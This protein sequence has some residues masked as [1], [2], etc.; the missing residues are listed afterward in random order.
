Y[1]PGNAYLDALA[2]HRRAKGLPATAIA[3][4]HW[5][6]ATPGAEGR[7][8]R[9]GAQDLDPEAALDV[10]RGILDHDDTSV[11]VL[12]CAWDDPAWSVPLLAELR[13]VRRGAAAPGPVAVTDPDGFSADLAR[14]LAELPEAERAGALLELVRPVIATVLRH[15]SPAA[16]EPDQPFK[17]LG[18]DSL[19]AVELRNRLRAATGLRLTATLIYDHPTPAA[20]ADHLYAELAPRP[21]TTVVPILAELDRLAAVLAAAAVAGAERQAVGDRLQ[22][23]LAGWRATAPGAV[24]GPADTVTA[25]EAVTDDEL[26]GLLGDEFGIYQPDDS[27]E[28]NAHE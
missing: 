18:F 8:R 25:L 22:D 6:G 15:S 11:A 17:D 19:T 27:A 4:G 16:I 5:D 28:G 2:H 10:L 13:A 3:W 7:I 20:L 24:A 14:R 26:I 23:L 12:R 9:H 21:D 1:A